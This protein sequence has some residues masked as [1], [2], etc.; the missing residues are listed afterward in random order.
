MPYLT[1]FGA[2]AAGSICLAA[3]IIGRRRSGGSNASNIYFLAMASLF[4]ATVVSPVSPA[5]YGSRESAEISVKV[6]VISM[7]FAEAMLWSVTL[8]FPIDR[9]MSFKPLSR[10]AVV[11][12]ASAIAVVG[13]GGL[14]AV[15]FRA[16]DDFALSSLTTR[17][18]ILN[19]AVMII[20]ATISLLRA[21]PDAGT[22]AR[23]GAKIY[24]GGLWGLQ[25]SALPFVLDFHR[26]IQLGAELDVIKTVLVIVGVGGFGAIFGVTIVRNQ[27]MIAVSPVAERLVSSTKSQYKLLRR[28]VYLVEEPKPDFAFKMFTDILKGRC[29]DCEEDESF[30][31]ESIDC[32]SC[33]LPCP[34][35]TCTKYKTRTQGLIVTRQFPIEVRKKHYIQTTPIIWLST[36]QG[37]D[38]MDPAKLALLT[39]YLVNFMESSKNGVVLVE[40]IEYL[41]ISNDFQRLLKA[42]DAWTESAMTSRSRLILSVDR[43]AFDSKE[44]AML[45]R[46]RETVRPDAKENWMI[47]PERI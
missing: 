46:N 34:C 18:L 32:T 35:H 19:G 2:I 5:F 47:I 7:L 42:V 11:L 25:L 26:G 16:K 36:V 14:A 45:E 10:C 4:V 22:E 9:R 41:L 6:F 12:I 43:K 24:L 23:R 17:I 37:K 39:D 20:L 21:M 44:L 33:G 40:G 3:G 38:N 28:L 1:W 31:C 15:D 13:L 29:Y 30:P 27:L 8:V